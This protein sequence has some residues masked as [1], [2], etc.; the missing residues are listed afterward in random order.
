MHGDKVGLTIQLMQPGHPNNGNLLK[1]VS[2]DFDGSGL[3][4]LILQITGG[5]YRPA[6]AHSPIPVRRS[7][8]DE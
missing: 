6:L 2:I 5:V 4:E 8:H 7:L 3:W 1:L